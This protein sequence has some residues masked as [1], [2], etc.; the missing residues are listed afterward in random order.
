M[1]DELLDHILNDFQKSELNENFN[2]SENSVSK[3]IEEMKVING[4]IN[5]NNLINNHNLNNNNSNFPENENENNS[6]NKIENLI[7]ECQN[8]LEFINFIE[9]DYLKIKENNESENFVL[10]NYLKTSKLNYNVIEI[11]TENDLGNLIYSNKDGITAA[12]S[13]GSV[14]IIGDKAGNVSFYSLKT[15]KL[16]KTFIYPLKKINSNHDVYCLDVTDEKDYLIVG[17]KNGGIALF[18][19]EKTKNKFADETIHFKSNSNKPNSILDIKIYKRENNNSLY[20]YS[21]DSEGN[22]FDTKITVNFFGNFRIS[23]TEIFFTNPQ[24]PTFL[25][26]NIKFTEKVYKSIPN[27]KRIGKGIIFASLFDI[28]IYLIEPVFSDLFFFK[29][30]NY[31]KQHYYV[32]DVAIGLGIPPSNKYN[33]DKINNQEEILLLISWEKVIYAFMIPVLEGTYSKPVLLG[34]YISNNNINKVGFLDNSIIYFVDNDNILKVVNS[35]NFNLGGINLNKNYDPI[36]PVDNDL[37]LIDKGKLI[38][39]SIKN[40]TILMALDDSIKQTYNYSILENNGTLFLLGRDHIY[41][42]NLVKWKSLLNYSLKNKNWLDFFSLGIQIFQGKISGLIDLPVNEEDRKKLIGDYLKENINNFIVSEIGKKNLNSSDSVLLNNDNEDKG[43]K[44]IINVCIECCINIEAIEELLNRIYLIF[45]TKNYGK[46]FLMELEPF[47]IN[48]KMKDYILK[49]E[50]VLMIIDFFDKKMKTENLNNLLIHLNISSVDNEIIIEKCKGLKLINPLIYIYTNG[51]NKNY[52]EPIN[53]LFER[54]LKGIEIVEFNNNNEYNYKE[55]IKSKKKS[56]D[57]IKTSKQFYG[58]KLLWFIN[59]CLSGR[60]YPN[61]EKIDE[62]EFKNLVININFW[63]IDKE[64]MRELVKFDAKNYFI[65]LKNIYSVENTYNFILEANNDENLMKKNVIKFSDEKFK[66]SDIKPVSLINYIYYKLKDNND[67]FV[68]MNLF[69]FIAKSGKFV[70]YDDKNLIINSL[71]FILKNYEF[72]NK[73][74][75]K[76]IDE[77][78]N[79]LIELINKSENILKNGDYLN[80]ILVVEET[81]FYKVKLL[82]YE[83]VKNYKECL[84]L[85]LNGKIENS[86]NLI[87]DWLNEKLLKLKQE[88][89]ENFEELKN[90]IFLKSCEIANFNIEKFKLLID[91]FFYS[92]KIELIKK[93]ERNNSKILLEYIKILVNDIIEIYNKDNDLF[94]DNNNDENFNEMIIFILKTHIKLLCQLNYKNE[95]LPALK[96]FDLYPYEDCIQYCLDNNV[97][98]A[99]IFLYKNIGENT[100]A[101]KICIKE[102]ETEFNNLIEKI[103]KKNFNLEETNFLNEIFNS[104]VEIC[105][106]SNYKN[107]DEDDL[108]FI[109]LDKLYDFNLK[110]SQINNEENNKNLIYL[111]NKILNNIQ[112]LLDKMCSNVNI[113]TLKN[114]ILEKYSKAGM[115]E[116]KNIIIHM[117][118]SY[119]NQQIILN[120]GRKILINC[121]SENFSLFKKKIVSGNEFLINKCDECNKKFNSN[122]DCNEKIFLFN[123]KHVLHE[124]CVYKKFN[125][126]NEEILCRICEKNEIENKNENLIG[127]NIVKKDED[128]N[129]ENQIQINKKNKNKFL[130]KKHLKFLK[131]FDNSL[132]EKKNLMINDMINVLRKEMIINKSDLINKKN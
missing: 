74:N 117:I 2:P 90:L 54:F 43:I 68:L 110:I 44:K 10:S 100:E 126:E 57:E 55:L 15:K 25:I 124:K 12:L 116:F 62:N 129:N 32:P 115:K 35:R 79:D 64:I 107:L 75:N 41:N 106:S 22:V 53:L 60:K 70:N 131:Y 92:E 127:L 125:D 29:R 52:F 7:P 71:V 76:E 65:L 123:C 104:C 14:L 56:L 99:A 27:L 105:Y 48:D 89:F 42:C 69:I 26:K 118:N 114:I 61:F 34:N 84:E 94:I 36:V 97:N 98:D 109:L 39:P 6:I 91:K 111:D 83:K 45:E 102:L 11:N 20:F 119:G 13:I 128:D 87:F 28:R 51:K 24:I 93:M 73:N 5:D 38:D 23:K 19:I 47:I 113:K 85:L 50:N 108:G 132:I 72:F 49:E 33:N 103:L 1:S 3:T 80:I 67:N 16:E 101:L 81:I 4:F 37:A 9:N 59:L 120:I 82:L 66:I 63:L 96:N 46:L 112:N 8:P 88:D 86:S 121:V 95:V 77:I 58:H 18:D 122:L 78:S 31:I 40:Q 17:Y 30:P 130:Y 21:S